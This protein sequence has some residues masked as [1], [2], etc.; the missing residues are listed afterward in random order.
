LFG[1]AS[2]TGWTYRCRH[3]YAKKFSIPNA[4]NQFNFNYLG[5]YNNFLIGIAIGLIVIIL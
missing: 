3:T 5:T 4:I 1:F 2:L